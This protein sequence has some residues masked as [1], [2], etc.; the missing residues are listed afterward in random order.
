M[1]GSLGAITPKWTKIALQREANK[2]KTRGEFQKN[3]TAYCSA[4]SHNLIN[5]LFKNHPNQGYSTIR[6]KRNYWT[7]EKLQEEANKC[8]T[9]SEF[10][11]TRAYSIAQGKKIVN[12]LFENHVNKGYLKIKKPE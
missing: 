3:S 9:R 5:E 4:V 7:L 10:S 11:K 12:E 2:Y 6:N 8:K 1:Y